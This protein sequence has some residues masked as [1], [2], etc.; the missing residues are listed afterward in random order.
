MSTKGDSRRDSIV[1]T[2]GVIDRC[3]LIPNSELNPSCTAEIRNL[4]D[5]P[6][7]E[8]G[9]VAIVPALNS[10]IGSVQIAM[11]V[12][13]LARIVLID[14]LTIPGNVVNR[15]LDGID[16]TRHRVLCHS[17][18]ISKSPAKQQAA[19]CMIVRGIGDVSKIKSF[20]GRHSSRYIQSLE[21]NVAYTTT[22][23][24]E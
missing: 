18:G 4:A 20:D 8:T 11:E 15:I 17:H 14:H 5:V 2:K 12:H 1:G 23:N 22:T 13:L 9:W 6:C 10:R 7:R 19:R 16:A 24:E 3:V 21:I